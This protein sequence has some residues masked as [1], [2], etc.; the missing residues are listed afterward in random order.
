MHLF[1]LY[2]PHPSP[3]KDFGPCHFFLFYV[4]VTCCFITQHQAR[5]TAFLLTL[6]PLSYLGYETLRRVS[7]A[8]A[9]FAL[10]KGKVFKT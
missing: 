6:P 3:Q 10:D 7:C 5:N 4:C 9:V 8:T 2:S 1:S